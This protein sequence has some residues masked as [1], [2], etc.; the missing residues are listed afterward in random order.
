MDK[1][2]ENEAYT[3]LAESTNKT[4]SIT[5]KTKYRNIKTGISEDEAEEKANQKMPE[6][7]I[8]VFMEKLLLFCLISW[9]WEEVICN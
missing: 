3:G 4:N 1:D 9:D 8:K 7:N 6:E 5:G 2:M